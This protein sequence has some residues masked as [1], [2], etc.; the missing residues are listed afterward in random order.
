[1]A[2]R[3]NP[4][5]LGLASLLLALLTTAGCGGVE[6][7]PEDAFVEL[8]P[9]AYSFA[10]V[11]ECLLEAA[12]RE[13]FEIGT[14]SRDAERGEFVTTF[15]IID[16][17][18]VAGTARAQRLRATTRAGGDGAY[19]VRLAATEWRR[20]GGGAWT[21]AGTAPALRERFQATYRDS[22]TRRY[23]ERR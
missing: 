16:R 9:Q 2:I 12:E 11:W 10:T 5:L 13:G 19:L 17:D 1:M 4:G 7:E 21:Y 6:R 8:P 22:L 20:E 23:Q 14:S 18:V 15:K 3:L